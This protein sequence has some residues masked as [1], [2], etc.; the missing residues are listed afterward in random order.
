MSTVSSS[1]S[2]RRAGRP[3]AAIGTLAALAAL[4]LAL[5]GS[6]LA[7]DPS[8]AASSLPPSVQAWLDSDVDQP[9]DVPPGGHVIV[10]LT[11]WDP[12]AQAF[13][14]FA[15]VTARLYPRRGHAAPSAADATVD[16]P[17][18]LTFALAPPKGGPGRVE[19]SVRG[20]DRPLKVEGVGPPPDAPAAA[21]LDAETLPIVGDVVAGRPVTLVAVLRQRGSWAADAVPFPDR[22]IVIASDASGADLATGELVATSGADPSYRGRLTIPDAGE[23]DISFAIPGE[24]GT[25][26]QV[27]GGVPI[28]VTVIE[29][30]LRPDEERTARPVGSG[31]PAS[32]PGAAGDGGGPPIIWLALGGLLVLAVVLMFG[33]TVRGWLRRGE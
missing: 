19:F 2:V 31:E 9:P 8:P 13:S 21:L 4:V 17:G 29:S 24:G 28:H 18:H 10:G 25:P 6:A 30:G 12:D 33:G 22:L 16:V 7:A 15:D 32:A 1:G 11:L 26:D 14:D 27:I 5:P 23:A 3:A 20:Q